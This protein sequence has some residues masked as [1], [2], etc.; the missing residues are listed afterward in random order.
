MVLQDQKQ[1]S[2]EKGEF[3]FIRMKQRGQLIDYEH[4]ERPW[5]Y[6][7][8]LAGVHYRNPYQTRHTYASQLLS[9]GESPLF[10]AQQM[11][12][13][14]TEM[15]MRHYGRWV[16]QAEEKHQH[17]FVSGFGQSGGLT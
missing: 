4:L 6:I 3:V 16:E 7:L 11:G 5:K 10:V 1:Y 13:K 14:T 8:K 17:V 12:H 2:L 9:G 15:I